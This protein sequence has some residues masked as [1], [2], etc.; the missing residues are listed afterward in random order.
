M[1]QGVDMAANSLFVL[2]TDGHT[3]GHPLKIAKPRASTRVR[4][5][6]FTVRIVNDWN[7]L[8]ADVVCA[9]GLN[10]FKSKLDAHWKSQWYYIP[11]WIE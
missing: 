3:R 7:G 2:N 8:P 6:A 4:R 9:P 5:N 10:S 1:H 11:A